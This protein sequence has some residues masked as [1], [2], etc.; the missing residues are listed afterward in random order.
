MLA[1]ALLSNIFF[2]GRP[3]FLSPA[4]IGRPH[5]LWPSSSKRQGEEGGMEGGRGR[6]DGGGEGS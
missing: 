2:G 6:G 1:V 4:V 3:V 5:V